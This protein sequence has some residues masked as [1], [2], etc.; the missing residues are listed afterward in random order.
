MRTTD[1]I[2]AD[3]REQP[4]SDEWRLEYADACDAKDPA[5]AK[6]I[7][8]EI[9]LAKPTSPL[10]ADRG[11]QRVED[12][13]GH[14]FLQYCYGLTF[15]RGFIEE[16]TMD[17]YVFVD[18][19]SK[20]LDLAPIQS[21]TFTPKPL[22][23]GMEMPLL[24]QRVPSAVPEV[25]ACP[26]VDRL[27]SVGFA[28]SNYQV[29]HTQEADIDAVLSCKYLTRLLVLELPQAGVEDRWPEEYCRRV[30]TAAFE[31]PEF[32][33]MITIDFPRYPGERWR[34]YEDGYFVVEE[35]IPM[36]EFGRGLERKHGYLPALHLHNT[37]GDDSTW[38]MNTK[39][40]VPAVVRGELPRFPVGAPVTDAMY[41]LPEAK[42]RP[43]AHD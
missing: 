4:E 14:P 1:Q 30:W 36:T 17:P 21:I 37:W 8:T 39:D 38:R 25:M 43:I 15:R 42:R 22:P 2:L 33:K 34:S 23:Y 6:Y 19:G 20:L 13:I 27:R 35:P 24:S 26:H 32:R 11:S 3:I 12:R 31:R 40:V 18:Q 29:W 41:V 7:R 10:D 9:E 5:Y 28:N 16:V